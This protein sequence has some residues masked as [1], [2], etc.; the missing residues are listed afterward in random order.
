MF[1]DWSV[2]EGFRPMVGKLL[3]NL[4][5]IGCETFVSHV[6]CADGAAVAWREFFELGQYILF[7]VG[8]SVIVRLFFV[9]LDCFV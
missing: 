8:G 5:G 4:N 9:L 6:E 2:G 1:V 7:S 3:C